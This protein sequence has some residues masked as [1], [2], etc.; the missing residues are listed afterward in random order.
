MGLQCWVVCTTAAE[1]GVVAGGIFPIES[2]IIVGS[3]TDAEFGVETSS[4]FAVDSDV[5]AGSIAAAEFGVETGSLF[6]TYL[7]LMLGKEEKLNFHL[8]MTGR[9]AD[10]EADHTSSLGGFPTEVVMV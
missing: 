4:L 7:Y 1:F 2:S 5:V 10:L 9:V 6:A 3:T 8:N